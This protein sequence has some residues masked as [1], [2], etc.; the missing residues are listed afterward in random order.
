M[1]NH[2]KGIYVQKGKLVI[3]DMILK[4]GV[5]GWK[6]SLLSI[7]VLIFELSMFETVGQH[8]AE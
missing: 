4:V 6:Q 2:Q 5:K 7:V 1:P 3:R 8:V